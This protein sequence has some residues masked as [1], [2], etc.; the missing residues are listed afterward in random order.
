[1]PHVIPRVYAERG[2][3]PGPPI[4][5]PGFSLCPATLSLVSPQGDHFLPTC[6]FLSAQATP[7][8]FPGL[9]QLPGPTS[10]SPPDHLRACAQ[11][12]PRSLLPAERATPPRRRWKLHTA[13]E[14]RRAERVNLRR[15]LG[16]WP[17]RLWLLGSGSWL[18]PWAGQYKLTAASEAGR[19]RS[20][21]A[22]RSAAPAGAMGLSLLLLAALLLAVLFKVYLGLFARSS[23]N[24]FSED[25]RRPPA[26]LVTDREARK[27][28]LKQSKREGTLAS[29]AALGHPRGF[30]FP[31]RQGEPLPT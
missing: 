24:P 16:F 31:V 18:C 9:L 15:S 14:I 6:L 12:R 5:Q 3:E 1:M 10:R 22:S 19:S 13:A 21:S 2:A 23:P 29:E 26:P 7:D 28:V 25:V 30:A 8:A 20:G 17:K 27:K 11:R 4:S